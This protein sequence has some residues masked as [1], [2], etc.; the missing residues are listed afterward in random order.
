MGRRNDKVRRRG[1]GR[2]RAGQEPLTRER[3]LGAGLRIVDEEGIEALSMRRLAAELG[4]NPMS[5]YHHLP[6][7]A[8]VVSGLVGMVF[9]GMRV[10]PSGGLPWRGRVR[11]HAR[12]PPGV[13]RSHPHLAPPIVS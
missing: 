6:G 2:P 4:V 13:V 10:P 11:A 3:I 1:A 8:A 12:A 5:I 7:K 9:S